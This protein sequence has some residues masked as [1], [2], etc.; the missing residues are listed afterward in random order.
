MAQNFQVQLAPFISVIEKPGA[1]DMKWIDGGHESTP[2]AGFEAYFG[3]PPLYRFINFDGIAGVAD[4]TDRIRDL[5]EGTSAE[6]TMRKLIG[7]DEMYPAPSVKEALDRLFK[8]VDEDPEIDVSI[9]Q[10]Q[11]PYAR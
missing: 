1:L 9:G 4:M 8:I 10:R 2:P 6:E 5:P 3:A 7:D 11:P